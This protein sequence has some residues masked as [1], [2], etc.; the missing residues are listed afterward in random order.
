[1]NR[2]IDVCSKASHRLMRGIVDIEHVER[3]KTV[4]MNRK[5]RSGI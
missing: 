2:I 5:G 4:P 1:M 3:F